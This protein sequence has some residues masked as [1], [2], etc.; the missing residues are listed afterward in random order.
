VLH[1]C[2]LAG[3]GDKSVSI[4]FVQETDRGQLAKN[5]F[6]GPEMALQRCIRVR[7]K[8]EETR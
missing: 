6:L 4:S 3:R 8:R 1:T 5:R 2:R 7:L